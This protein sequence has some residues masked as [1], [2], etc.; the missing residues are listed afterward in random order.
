MQKSDRQTRKG[1]QRYKAGA[2][3][4]PQLCIMHWQLRQGNCRDAK[5]PSQ[6][7]LRK[8]CFLRCLSSSASLCCISRSRL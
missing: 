8:A 3:L 1:I 5:A 2:Q 7:H 4:V 6:A